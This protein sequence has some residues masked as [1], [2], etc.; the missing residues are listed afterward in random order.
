M[1]ALSACHPELRILLADVKAE[2]DDDT[3]RLILADWLQDQGDVRGEL[4]HLQVVRH[5]IPEDDPRHAELFR[6]E[7]EILGHHVFDWLGPLA[8][9]VASWD[10]S[11]GF[12]ILSARAQ[13]FLVPAIFE[14][15][16]GQLFDWVE[17]VTLTDLR[18]EHLPLLTASPLLARL[19]RL[20][21]S[22]TQLTNLGVAQLLGA[23]DLT[24]LHTLRL[25]GNRIGGRGVAVL[26]NCPRLANLRVLDLRR[27]RLGDAGAVALAESPYLTRLSR[28]EVS[29]NGLTL[30]GLATLR[31]AFGRRVVPGLQSPF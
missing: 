13:R 14:L 15:I 29:G 23:P 5:R 28:L 3:P 18:P 27:N 31:K 7:R 30:A 16:G 11:R 24:A 9:L 10:F 1:S 19:M 4:I 12:I 17:E 22:D 6:R 26:A 2:P 21:L 8:D 25:A 20:D